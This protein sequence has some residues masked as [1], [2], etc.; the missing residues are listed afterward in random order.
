MVTAAS[1]QGSAKLQGKDFI[2][3]AIFGLLLFIVFFAFAMILGMNANTFWFTHAIG[4][5]PGGIVWMYLPRACRSRA[6]RSPCRLSWRSWAF[7]R[8]AVDGAGGHR[9]GRR[10]G[11]DYHDGGQTIEGGGHRGVRSVDVVLLARAGVDGVSRG[12]FL[13]R[14]GGSIGHE[15]RVRRDAR[16]VHAEPPIIVAGVLCVVGPIV[17]GLLGSKT[18]TSTSRALPRNRSLFSLQVAAP[19]SGWQLLF[20]A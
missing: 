5:I 16:R 2:F 17:G 4:A 13:R 10:A 19:V 14:H 6:R 8:Y 20:S 9:R 18:S 15:P 3:I 11:G 7:A 1:A 12:R